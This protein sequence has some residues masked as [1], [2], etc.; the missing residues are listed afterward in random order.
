MVI[1]GYNLAELALYSSRPRSPIGGL[2]KP[3]LSER[4][5][6]I[7]PCI[8][9]WSVFSTFFAL[10]TEG[11]SEEQRLKSDLFNHKQP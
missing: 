11:A 9:F 6:G 10:P 4:F 7:F 5:W 2:A 8:S 1:C 3:L